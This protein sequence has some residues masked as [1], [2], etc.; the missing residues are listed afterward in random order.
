MRPGPGVEEAGHGLPVSAK[1]GRVIATG[2][3]S[4]LLKENREALKQN[5][6]VIFLERELGELATSG[7]PLS[8]NLEKL[9]KERLPLYESICDYKLKNCGGI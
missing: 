6:T 1:A 5:G 7:R 3:G 8:V 2:G 9:Y 4:V